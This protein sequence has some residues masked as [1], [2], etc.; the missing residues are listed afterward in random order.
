MSKTKSTFDIE[1]RIN[2]RTVTELK[3]LVQCKTGPDET[4]KEITKV[5]TISK[6]RASFNLTRP[7]KV[8]CLLSLIMPLPIEYRAYDYL[9]DLYPVMVLVQYC[10]E[11]S[12]DNE[13]VYDVG[14]AFVGKHIPESYLAN[15]MQS[16]HICGTTKAGLWKITESNTPFKDRAADRFWIPL[17][18]TISLIQKEKGSDYKEETVTHNINATG[19]SVVCA[20]ETNIGDRVRFVSRE[21]D[22][23][24][25]AVVRN[26]RAR[27]DNLWTIHL[28]F[29]DVRFPVE[30][31]LASPMVDGTA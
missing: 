31:I 22:F 13:P 26:R 6:N 17:S 28:E 20:L 4:W 7:C 2:K 14:V 10:H 15:P 5:S 16:Y 12:I 30:K 1:N 11:F 25:I 27:K 3:T 21:H 8:G 23:Y 29:V 9:D 18:V 19:A 24:T